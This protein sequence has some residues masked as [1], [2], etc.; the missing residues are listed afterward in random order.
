MSRLVSV[1]EIIKREYPR[2]QGEGLALY[3]YNE[4]GP[5]EDQHAVPPTERSPTSFT[6]SLY[7]A[8]FP[9]ART[10]F[11]IEIGID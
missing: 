6:N 7:V 3:Q 10:R 2:Q 11:L 4:F 9:Y 8:L 5:L 1:V